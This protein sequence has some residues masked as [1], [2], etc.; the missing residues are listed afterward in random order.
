MTS[1]AGRAV[2]RAPAQRRLAL[3]AVCDASRP[4]SGWCREP[5]SR[6]LGGGRW[7]RGGSARPPVRR[8]RA[9]DAR[10]PSRPHQRWPAPQQQHRVEVASITPSPEVQAPIAT[11]GAVAPR[12]QPPQHRAALEPLAHDDLE[13][14]ERPVGGAHAV[15]VIDAHPDDAR[16]RAGVDDLPGGS[17]AD[18]CPR[19]GVEVHAAVA[20]TV[21]RGGRRE[22]LYHPTV[23]GR[24]VVDLR[25]RGRGNGRQ[26][27]GHG[28]QRDDRGQAT[29]HHDAALPRPGTR[30]VPPVSAWPRDREE[31]WTERTTRGAAAMVSRPVARRA[32]RA[33]S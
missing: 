33:G 27:P 26:H 32:W 3:P 13:A 30:Y 11:V 22:R 25:C 1:T 17:G 2:P 15:R 5:R 9:R 28:K 16:D 29:Q 21:A 23:D 14:C 24:D 10:V 31:V 7:H 8:A 12:R 18:P 4:G 20:R 19:R 6:R